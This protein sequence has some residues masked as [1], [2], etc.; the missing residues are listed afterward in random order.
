MGHNLPGSNPTPDGNPDARKVSGLAA[1][2]Q[3]YG[4]ALA[5]DTGMREPLHPSK[6]LEDIP[7]YD[8]DQVPIGSTF[9]V[10]CE[11]DTGLV[12][13]FD[14]SI[15]GRQR[16]VLVPVGHARVESN[17]GRYRLRLRA[18]TVD[19]LERIPAYEPHSAWHEDQF[20]DDLLH[21]YGRL[22]EGQRYYAH[23]A[24]DH[25][26]LYAGTHP[27]LREPLEG[28]PPAGLRRLA[29]SRDFRIADGEPDIRGWSLI[30][31]DGTGIGR[32][33]DLIVD[34]EDEEVRYA[35]IQRESDAGYT[36]LPIGYLR[37]GEE[38]IC[39]PLNG[40][41]LDALPVIEGETLERADEARLRAVLESV[42]SGPRRYA[43]PD[44]RS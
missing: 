30:G 38:T 13:Y 37:L 28:A 4:K 24:Y 18:T 41:D 6:D 33:I 17:L 15:D 10:L 14:V 16:H 44:F 11:A 8:A 2:R 40:K 26:G 20:Q 12:R 23:P 43:R 22:F 36:A 35:F 5:I 1:G 3:A 9:G 21:A 27:L 29:A 19:Q 39:V 31:D 7:V 42:L 34:T 25:A 32:V